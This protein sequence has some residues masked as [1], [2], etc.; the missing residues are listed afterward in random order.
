MSKA[1]EKYKCAVGSLDTF[2]IVYTRGSETEYGDFC[3]YT[4]REKRE[5]RESEL[6]S[7]WDQMKYL[8]L[9]FKRRISD[10]CFLLWQ[11]CQLFLNI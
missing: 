9:I 11:E 2:Y 3:N 5:M 6:M 1:D 7:E 4:L 8:I 10:C